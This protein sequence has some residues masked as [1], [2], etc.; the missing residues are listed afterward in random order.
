MQI[1]G[2]FHTHEN[3]RR[4]EGYQDEQKSDGYQQ[5]PIELRR[6]RRMRMVQYNE[7]KSAHRKEETRR[8]SFHYVLTVHAIR[9]ECDLEK[10]RVITLGSRR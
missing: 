3:P 8:Q 7:T 4:E 1:T 10:K 5:Y 9:H 6:R 2:Q